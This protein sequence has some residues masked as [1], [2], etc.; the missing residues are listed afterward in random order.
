MNVSS[1]VYYTIN[2]N[3]YYTEP[4]KGSHPLYDHLNMLTISYTP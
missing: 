3:D 2:N 1:F 4:L